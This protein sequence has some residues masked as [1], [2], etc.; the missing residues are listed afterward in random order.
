METVPALVGSF[1]SSG[2]R[3]FPWALCCASRRQAR[4][5]ILLDR[6][7]PQPILVAALIGVGSISL[8]PLVLKCTRILQLRRSASS[9]PV[10]IATSI[11]GSL[12]LPAFGRPTGFVVN[13]SPD[14]ATSFDLRGNVVEVLSKAHRVGHATLHLKASSIPLSAVLKIGSSE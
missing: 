10:G 7:I 12:G 1:S 6:K 13:N 4:R 2:E 9:L 5:L 14:Q 11:D 8:P 3:L